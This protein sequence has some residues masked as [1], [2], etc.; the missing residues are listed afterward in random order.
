M[1][2]QFMAFAGLLVV[3]SGC[4]FQVLDEELPKYTGRNADR[5]IDILGLPDEEQRIAG[6]TIYVWHA[7]NSG[8]Y[9]IP[10]YNTGT[11]TS[12][13]PYGPAFG[14]YGYTTYQTH[15]DNYSCEIKVSVTPKNIIDHIEYE[16]QQGACAMFARQ[17]KN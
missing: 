10:Q 1:P 15:H 4:A 7:Q 13:G 5:L 14:S 3:I 9:T 12:Y 8:I 2:F 11:V 16:G 6:R 17:L